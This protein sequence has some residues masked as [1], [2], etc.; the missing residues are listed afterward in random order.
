MS[1]GFLEGILRSSWGS[2]V[3]FQVITGYGK[4]EGKVSK[5]STQFHSGREDFIIGRGMRR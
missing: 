4:Q 2:E 5:V 3:W 1:T